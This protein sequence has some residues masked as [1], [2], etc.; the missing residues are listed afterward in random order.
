[1]SEVPIIRKRITFVSNW[2]EVMYMNKSINIY[3]IILYGKLPDSVR[4]MAGSEA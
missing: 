1:M 2:K 3:G 4:K